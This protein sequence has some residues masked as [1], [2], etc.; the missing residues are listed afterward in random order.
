[1]LRALFATLIGISNPWPPVP[2]LPRPTG[3]EML[4]FLEERGFRLIMRLRY[5]HWKLVLVVI[6]AWTLGSPP[7]QGTELDALTGRIVGGTSLLLAHQPDFRTRALHEAALR[8]QQSRYASPDGLHRQYAALD[9]SVQQCPPDARLH[10]RPRGRVY[11]GPPATRHSSAGRK[12]RAHAALECRPWPPAT[13][14]ASFNKRRVL[15][16]TPWGNARVP[17]RPGC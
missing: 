2:K 17:L 9:R 15:A 6:L 7:A 13:P 5:L 16:E 4:R 11:S 10:A 14:T 1:M 12:T 8:F 3:K